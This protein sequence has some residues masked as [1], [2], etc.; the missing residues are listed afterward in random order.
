MK[1]KSSLALV[2]AVALT[3]V[4]AGCSSS[5]DAGSATASTSPDPQAEPITVLAAASLTEGF[6]ELGEAYQ[7]AN[8]GADVSF[9][10]AAS[11]TLALQVQAGSP[12]DV[13]ATADHS[14]METAMEGKGNDSTVFAENDL[15]IAVAKGNPTSIKD[16]ADLA[17]ESVTV[18]RCAPAV[19]CGKLT[20]AALKAANVMLTGATEGPDVKATFSPLLTSQ[21]DAAFVYRTDALTAK[22][23]VDVVEL[24]D[25]VAQTTQYP[26]VAVTGAGNPFVDFVLSDEGTEILAK[27]GFSTP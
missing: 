3:A 7:E 13:L 9:S 12:G 27:Y 2:A 26:I 18:S 8:P 11:S 22:D 5:S 4:L 16:I 25:N 14:S 15:V 6:E 19:P 17:N 23:T 24:A 20:D 10:F 21:V 1:Y